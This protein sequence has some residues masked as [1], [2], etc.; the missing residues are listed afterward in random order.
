MVLKEKEDLGDFIKLLLQGYIKS[1]TRIL[2]HIDKS[3]P[4]PSGLI[5]FVKYTPNK[6]GV[7][8]RVT[9][10]RPQRP[11]FRELPDFSS[12]AIFKGYTFF[13]KINS[14]MNKNQ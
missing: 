12:L 6:M 8:T 7:A 14:R 2:D 5:F 11:Y 13:S 4:G 3:V 9:V 1:F 10:R